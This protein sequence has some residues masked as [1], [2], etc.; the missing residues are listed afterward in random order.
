MGASGFVGSRVVEM[1]HLGGMGDIRPIVRSFGSLARLARFDLEYKIANALDQKDLVNAFEGCDF[2]VHSV[3]GNPEV[4]EG[5]ISATYRAAEAAGVK[6]IAY[7]SSASVFGQAPSKGTNDS[8]PLSDRQDQPYNNWKVRAER[9]LLKERDKGNVEVV[10][11]RPG[12]VFGPRDRWISAIAADLV[13]GKAYLVNGGT[14]ICNSIYVDNLVQAVHL[15]LTA[16]AADGEAFIVG[17]A[18][19]VTWR[20]LYENVAGALGLSPN[21]IHRVSPPRFNKGLKERVDKF[22]SLGATQAALPFFP[23]K[24][25]RSVKAALNAWPETPAAATAINSSGPSLNV[26]LEMSEL[27]QCG[28]KLPHEKAEQLLGYKPIVSFAEGC[29]RSIGWLRF[30]GYDVVN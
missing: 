12:I 29:R 1:F 16:K 25:K 22:R 28:Y 13:R 14:G 27:H 3:A 10:I 24:L 9:K 23:P 30:A 17:D 26:T 15:S 20:D 18:E 6:R 5:S 8:T 7:I 21:E 2:V 11:L 4:I 19:T